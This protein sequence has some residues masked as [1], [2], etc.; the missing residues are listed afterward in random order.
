M[1]NIVSYPDMELETILCQG[2]FFNKCG[3]ERLPS[4]YNILLFLVT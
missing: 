2:I 4:W 3:N 1:N